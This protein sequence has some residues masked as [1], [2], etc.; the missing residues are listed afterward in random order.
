M[1]F[2]Q[3]SID[4]AISESEKNVEFYENQ[5]KNYEELSKNLV[6]YNESLSPSIMVPI[7]NRVLMKGNLIH[8]NEILVS[9]GC[10]YFVKTSS[11][12]AQKICNRRILQT[13]AILHDLKKESKFL[14]DQIDF[15]ES[16]ILSHD[17]EEI[18][19]VYDDEADREWRIKHRENVKCHLQKEKSEREAVDFN[20]FMIKLD[21][22]ELQE[23]MDVAEKVQD[24][25]PSPDQD[26]ELKEFTLRKRL[27]DLR[28]RKK[29]QCLTYE[30]TVKRLDELEE[31]EELEDELDRFYDENLSRNNHDSEDDSAESDDESV[32]SGDTI[33]DHTKETAS[34][35]NSTKNELNGTKIKR[36]VSFV[37][38]NFTSED[39]DTNKILINF[40]HSDTVHNRNEECSQK[41]NSPSDIYH[42]FPECV[43][44]QPKPIIKNCHK[45]KNEIHNLSEIESTSSEIVQ[46]V[47]VPEQIV[48]GDIVEHGRDAIKE[49]E[50]ESIPQQKP[51]SKFKSMRLARKKT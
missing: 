25:K 28:Q 33:I 31:E 32:E 29:T 3:I 38:N 4:K 37:D 27:A 11:K 2:W 46:C 1:D 5:K 7:C 19:E 17:G 43:K 48:I 45:V 20:D 15:S 50:F 40:S 30:D 18:I 41:I 22:L 49:Q 12:D 14:K 8:T 51:I 23:E 39:A 42:H 21:I 26:L 36:R 34:S 44:K 24:T 13:E 16:N 6:S 47:P 10:D 35:A 9:L